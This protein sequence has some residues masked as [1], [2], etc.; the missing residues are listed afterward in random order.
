MLSSRR[1]AAVITA[2][3]LV[4]AVVLA[5]CSST[6]PHPAASPSTTPPSTS[7]PSATATPATATPTP[8]VIHDVVKPA[9]P[10]HFV[11]RGPRFTIKAHV[12]GMPNVR[13]LDPPGE[14]HHRV[15]WVDHGFGVAPGS[16]SATTY[17]LGHSWAEDDLEVLNP[18]SRLATKQIL[19]ARPHRIGGIKT[20]PVTA[21]DGYTITLR[22]GNG[23]LVYTVR[24]AYGVAKDQAGFVPTLMD[25]KVPHRIAL[26]TCA[27]RRGVD[28][29]YDVIVDA[30]LTESIAYDAA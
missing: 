23:R 1:R 5:A 6:S 9:A 20:Y 18:A 25:E 30:Y 24:N 27:E 15:C 4:G 14:Q 11:F 29:P 26:I 10:T 16:D 12:C 22:T 8:R 28:Y 13:P 7:V 2:T 21:L 3:A 17:V 19:H